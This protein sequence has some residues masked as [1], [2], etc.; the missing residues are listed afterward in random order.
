MFHTFGHP[1]PD[2]DEC[3]TLLDTR[4]LILTN[5]SKNRAVQPVQRERFE[6]SCRA[7]RSTRML[8]R[9]VPCSRFNPNASKN[10]AVQPVQP[11]MLRRIVPC[12]PFK[13]GE[14]PGELP[15]RFPESLPAPLRDVMPGARHDTNGALV[16]ARAARTH[17]HTHETHMQTHTRRAHMHA[18]TRAHM[19]AC[20]T[21]NTHTHP[22]AHAAQQAH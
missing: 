18:C 2:F 12:S 15:E 20:T 10:R 19:H 9:I 1:T 17:T 4:P 21:N 11:G 8:R 16:N 13:P 7:A 6:E 14:P 5:T 22:H 3:F